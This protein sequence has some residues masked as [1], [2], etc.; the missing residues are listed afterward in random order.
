[1]STSPASG[2]R[3]Q[4][5]AVVSVVV[6]T[7]VSAVV[8]AAVVV[9]SSVALAAPA[10]ATAVSQPGPTTTATTLAPTTTTAPPVTTTTEP[11][12]TTTVPPTTTS[13][14][15]PA[16]TSTTTVP[17]TTTTSPGSKSTSSKTPW[18]LIVLVVVLVVA[19]ALVVVLLRSRKKRSVEAGW[20]RVVVPALSDAQ[21]ARDAVLSDNAM[22]SDPG[23]RGAVE[24]QVDRAATALERVARSAPDP[25]ASALATEAATALRGLAFAVE[26]DRLLRQG[27]S[28]PTGVQ[29]AQADEARRSRYSELSG[30]LASLSTRIGSPPHSRRAR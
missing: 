21:L 5:L 20:H 24:V 15:R 14:T 23:L 1:V 27:A 16:H 17:T 29:L 6:S 10:G 12:T 7:V 4:A 28:A 8:I 18:G 2:A 26:A 9:L 30:A 11:A 13:S 3:S 22:S 25:D 19:I